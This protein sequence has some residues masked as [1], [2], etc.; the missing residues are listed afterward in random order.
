[1]N[2]TGAVVSRGVVGQKHRAHALVAGVYIVEGMHEVEQ[3]QIFTQGRGQH[4]AGKL[5]AL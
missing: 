3:R 4:A 2:Q 1:M 5:V